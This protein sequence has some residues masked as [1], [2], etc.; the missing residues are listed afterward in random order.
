MNKHHSCTTQLQCGLTYKHTLPSRVFLLPSSTCCSK[1]KV[2]A[3]QIKLI[4]SEMALVDAPLVFVECGEA[5]PLWVLLLSLC[6]IQQQVLRV[7]GG[8][9]YSCLWLLFRSVTP[10]LRLVNIFHCVGYCS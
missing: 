4:K 10:H 7:H 6:N 9:G 8:P 3:N 5:T 2:A 1:K